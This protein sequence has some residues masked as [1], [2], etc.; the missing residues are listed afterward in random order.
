MRALLPVAA[1]LLVAATGGTIRDGRYA[2]EYQ[3]GAEKL[4]RSI[5]PL[6][7]PEMLRVCAALRVSPPPRVT[8]EV[9][10]SHDAFLPRQT[11]RFEPWVAGMADPG[12]NTIFL[13][14]LT[15]EEVRHNSLRAIAAHE[16]A[17]L[18]INAKVKGNPVPT[19]MDE[20]LCVFLANEPLFSRAERLIPIALTGR[21]FMFRDLQ[22]SFPTTAGDAA[23][24]YA[25]SGDFVRWLYR[26]HG[27]QAMLRYLDILAEGVDPDKALQAAFGLPLYD[28]QMQWMNSLGRVYGWIPSLTGGSFLWFLLA[29]VAAFA[30]WRKW[31]AMRRQRA[32]MAVEEESR[33]R[34][35]E[36]DRDR[37]RLL[38]SPLGRRRRSGPVS[39]VDPG[40]DEDEYGD[41]FE[42]DEEGLEDDGT[43]GD[44]DDDDWEDEGGPPRAH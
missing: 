20:G 39:A 15:G 9:A 31:R 36:L 41:D 42:V 18:A 8:V 3:A 29:L 32:E 23:T 34:L 43:F 44:D 27:E 28:L 26:E 30:Y 16:L 13:R 6:L 14:P 7:E 37:R 12:A 17:H 25:Q 4:A 40:D 1:F 10:A 33:V 2:I 11:D 22:G 24:A 19:W 35:R 38:L 5:A 21:A